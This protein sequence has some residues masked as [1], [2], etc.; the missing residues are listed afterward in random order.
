LSRGTSAITSAPTRGRSVAIVI[1]EFSQVI[2]AYP[3]LRGGLTLAYRLA[4]SVPHTP[5]RSS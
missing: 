1:A 3:S 5:L 4:S 2:S